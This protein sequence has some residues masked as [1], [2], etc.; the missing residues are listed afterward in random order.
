MEAPRFESDV[1]QKYR[2]QGLQVLGISVSAR[3]DATEKA[4]EFASKHKLTFPVLVDARNAVA[5]QFGVRGV[6]TFAVIGK[7][8]KLAY[9]K[10]EYPAKAV[11]G[12]IEAALKVEPPK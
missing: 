3:G 8:G 4:K 9:L 7:D 5:K 2:E 10:A 12:A 6:P 1:W 11:I